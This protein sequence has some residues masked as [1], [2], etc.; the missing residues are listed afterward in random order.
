MLLAC[1]CQS[2]GGAVHAAWTVLPTVWLRVFRSSYLV[3]AADAHY[4]LRDAALV[5]CALW[6]L[7]GS[8]MTATAAAVVPCMQVL[9]VLCGYLRL[10]PLSGCA[11]F[12]VLKHCPSVA[13]SLCMVCVC[14]YRR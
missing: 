6:L 1:T 2:F 11:A 9:L 14:G 10:Q 7:T 3:L 4:A 12:G 8:G 13:H 5:V